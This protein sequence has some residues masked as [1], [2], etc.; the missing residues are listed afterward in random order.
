MNTVVS[1]NKTEDAC[2]QL[3]TQLM[4]HSQGQ[5]NDDLLACILASW[6]CG[7]ADLPVFMGLVAEQFQ[8]MLVYH[9]P[10]FDA[11]QLL[12]PQVQLDPERG[13]ERNELLSLLLRNRAGDCKS[14]KWMAEIVSTACMAQNHLWQD[15]GLWSRKD[16]TRLLEKNFPALAARNDRNMKW[17]KFFYKQL[18]NA[19]G[20][21]VCRSP[22][23]EV[24]ADFQECFGPEE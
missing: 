15:L 1:S 11:Q 18:C 6:S 2:R 8:A 4:E 10:G 12:Q 16:L 21:Y 14:E 23:C 9:Y 5:A 24:C 19:E 3:H 13:H 7:Q 20:I 22:S 17:K